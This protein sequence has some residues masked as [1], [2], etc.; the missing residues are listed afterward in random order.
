MAVRLMHTH[1]RVL[2]ILGAVVVVVLTA[3]LQ[4]DPRRKLP[5]S[6]ESCSGSSCSGSS[7]SCSGSSCSCSGSCHWRKENNKKRGCTHTTRG[8]TLLLRCLHPPIMSLFTPP[9]L[10]GV[11]DRKKTGDI[12]RPLQIRLRLPDV[13]FV[14]TTWFCLCLE[15]RGWNSPPLLTSPQVLNPPFT[16][17]TLTY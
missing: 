6:A 4:G 14:C 1:A 8:V 15:L 2:F 3:D 7:C 11:K 13:P 16:V 17:L 9:S 5:G 10:P 12:P